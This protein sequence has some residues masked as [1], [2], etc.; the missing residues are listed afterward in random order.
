MLNNQKELPLNLYREAFG[1]SNSR[2]STLLQACPNLDEAELAIVNRSTANYSLPEFVDWTL[3]E[4]KVASPIQS[5][6]SIKLMRKR[7]DNFNRRPR[8]LK[9]IRNRNTQQREITKLVDIVEFGL[10]NKNLNESG[11]PNECLLV[12]SEIIS[13]QLFGRVSEEVAQLLLYE[14]MHRTGAQRQLQ[15]QLAFE[16]LD[17]KIPNGL[18]R[19][20]SMGRDIHLT[21]WWEH[22]YLVEG[23]FIEIY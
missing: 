9:S 3:E 7:Q 14:L 19:S 18:K 1:F 11:L 4:I 21:R 12:E 6:E 10:A 23:K 16:T 15:L 8:L 22:R 2:M 13:R 20:Y 17:H 5:P